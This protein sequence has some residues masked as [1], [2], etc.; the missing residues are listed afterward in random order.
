VRS[1]VSFQTLVFVLSRAARALAARAATRRIR[2][3]SAENK[4]TLRSAAPTMLLASARRF[5]SRPALGAVA[6]RQLAPPFMVR[7]SPLCKLPEAPWKAGNADAENA[8]AAAAAG[9]DDEGADQRLRDAQNIAS[10]QGANHL[11]GLRGKKRGPE[12]FV[13]PAFP[14]TDMCNPPGVTDDDLRAF[15]FERWEISSGHRGLGKNWN[16]RRRLYKLQRAMQVDGVWPLESLAPKSRLYEKE[17]LLHSIHR[18]AAEGLPSFQDEEGNVT[19]GMLQRRVRSVSMLA[20]LTHRELVEEI[21]QPRKPK[22]KPPR[23]NARPRS[24]I[25]DDL[26]PPRPRST[27]R[28]TIANDLD[29]R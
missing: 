24:T 1:G 23:P 2:T 20:A 5:A 11:G 10:A 22:P 19:D 18:I 6:A 9:Q 25:A 13:P 21:V 14:E 3:E 28:S 29:R 16:P 8:P 17:K 27:D 26:D 15:L 7:A 12:D 4:S